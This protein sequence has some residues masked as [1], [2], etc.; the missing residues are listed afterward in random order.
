MNVHYI[1][2][3][4]S[5]GRGI[6]HSNSQFVLPADSFELFI[7]CRLCFICGNRKR[8]WVLLEFCRSETP[9]QQMGRR[10]RKKLG[11]YVH[12]N[13]EET[14][15]T[16]GAPSRHLLNKPKLEKSRQISIADTGDE[17]ETCFELSR[18]SELAYL[19]KAGPTCRQTVEWR[20]TILL[21]L[22]L[23]LIKV[24]HRTQTGEGR[25]CSNNHGAITH[26]HLPSRTKFLCWCWVL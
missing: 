4:W 26:I 18:N 3:M 15:F 14:G 22:P 2:P 11:C 19:N 13:A 21:D 20:G 17:N 25:L 5:Q 10:C 23:T 1:V 24:L 9:R 6:N 7:L 8:L 12:A 16:A